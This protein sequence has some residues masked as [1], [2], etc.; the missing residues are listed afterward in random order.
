MGVKLEHVRAAEVGDEHGS[1]VGDV[2]FGMV[3]S[4]RGS[5]EA[6]NG[7]NPHVVNVGVGLNFQSTEIG[8]ILY[9]V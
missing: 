4:E 1:A 9:R 3:G 8:F 5:C 2:G 6:A 7:R